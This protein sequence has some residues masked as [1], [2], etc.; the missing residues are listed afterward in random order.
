MAH[1]AAFIISILLFLVIVVI[2]FLIIM[3]FNL[4]IRIVL[5]DKMTL[6]VPRTLI[7]IILKTVKALVR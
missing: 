3:I 2:G 5:I 7:I 1:K 6:G 4:G